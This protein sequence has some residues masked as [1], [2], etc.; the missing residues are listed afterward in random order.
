[1]HAEVATPWFD[2]ALERL[3]LRKGNRVLAV[4][5]RLPDVVALRAAIGSAGELTV[6][7]RD[8]QQAEELAARALPQLHVLAHDTDGGETF[9]TFDSVL[10]VLHTGPLLPADRYGE[11]LRNNLRPGGRFVADL[12]AAD[13]LPDLRAAWLELGWDEE[14]LAPVTGP[15][16][17]E[18]VEEL[19]SAHLRTVQSA[20]GSHL[21][22]VPSAAEFVAA[23]ADDLGLD[24]DEVAE[25]GHAI[26]RKRQDPGPMELLIHR[27]QATGQR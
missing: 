1:M 14:R 8:R 12:P 15:S 19:R 25:L 17:V 16:D 10:A 3:E 6:T 13:M 24:D 27:S 22:R 9:G 21:I 2:S 5:P 23:F 26:V 7:L 20:L 4:E 18:L 11:L